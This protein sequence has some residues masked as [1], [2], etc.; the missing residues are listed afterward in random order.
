[1]AAN[2]GATTSTSRTNYYSVAYGKLSNRVKNIPE[3][4]TEYIEADLKNKI[5]NVE[6]IDLRNRYLDK[7]KGDYPYQIFYDSLTGVITDQSKTE[8][9]HGTF[10]NI[11]VNDTDGDNSIIQLNFYSKY[12]ENLLN[13]L[14]AA[15]QG[16]ETTFFPY[17]IPN[18]AEIDGQNKSFYTQGIS[19]KQNG[20]KVEPKFKNDDK[21]LPPTEQVKVKG[22]TQT[23][24]DN[25][26]DFLYEEFLKVFKAGE[27]TA[28][29]TVKTEVPVD[30]TKSDI[31]QSTSNQEL[32]F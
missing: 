23:S 16:E 6:Q 30:T 11:T 2:S 31:P 10:L 22:K 20:Q 4:Y 21:E 29:Q 26:V 3:G 19:V 15:K 27:A 24:R 7:A 17:A 13:R 1:M 14:L 8:N 5:Q 18:V 28:T 9:E 12:A 25:R 32:P